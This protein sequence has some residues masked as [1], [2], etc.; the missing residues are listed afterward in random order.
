MPI[1]TIS[2]GSY[3]RGKEVAEMVA[4]RLGYEC[5]A[6]EV[7]MEAGKEFGIPEDKLVRAVHDSPTFLDKVSK[8][9]EKYVAHVQYALLKR[10]ARDNVVYH[11]LAGQYFVKGISHA[12]RVRIISDMADRVALEMEREKISRED[13]L[14]NIKK[15][16]EQ[17]TRWSMSLYGI[18]VSSPELFDLV[19]HVG[20]LTVEDAADI[21]VN[22]AGLKTFQATE[23]SA[24]AVEEMVTRYKSM[25]EHY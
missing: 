14:R 18:D 11:G 13:A 4:S 6:R 15:D 20:K 21:I 22:A 23:D 24:K 2:R 5:I 3:G 7:I 10:F 19:I 9:K 25:L 16:D 8:K 1:I 17:R 12:L